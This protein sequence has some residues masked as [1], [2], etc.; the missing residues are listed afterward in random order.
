MTDRRPD[1]DLLP[2]DQ[3]PRFTRGERIADAVMH[4]SGI[5]LA[6][7]GIVLLIVFAAPDAGARR[8]AAISVYGA[9]IIAL[10]IASAFF[11]LTPWEEK[12][13]LFRRIDQAA[14]YLKIAGTYTPLVVLI[15]TP[16]AYGVLAV[17]WLTALAG[18]GLKLLNRVTSARL[19]TTL[20]LLL[21]WMSLALIW[22]ITQTLPL[23]APILIL[24]GGVL[25]SLGV[26]ALYW[27]RLKF[28]MAIWHGFVL[29]ASGCFY[30]AITVSV[31]VT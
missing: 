6:I 22:S 4:A 7:T 21:G 2:I 9:T 28:S 31:F 20:Y 13:P 26:V 8:I 15:N 10:F 19:S 1:P 14:I 30:A 18:A 17:V 11:H 25:Y 29:A 27:P 23:A 24:S 16:L 3:Y 12:R 5:L